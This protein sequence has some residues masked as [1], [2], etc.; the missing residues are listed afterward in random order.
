MR[1]FIVFEDSAYKGNKSLKRAYEEHEFSEEEVQEFVRCSQDVN[2]FASNYVKV[3]HPD[4]GLIPIELYDYQQKLL[5]HF[6][7]NR[8]CIV[9]SSRQSGK[10]L[11]GETLVWVKES[12]ESQPKQISF[13]SLYQI[14][15]DTV[16][17]KKSGK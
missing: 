14:L 9:L 5:A 11:S 4:R 15:I 3:V 12:E 1:R 13:E 16:F 7:D 17:N 6:K 2:Y 10:C 8:N